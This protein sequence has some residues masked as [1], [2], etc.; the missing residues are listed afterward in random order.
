M[1]S[2]NPL[3]DGDSAAPTDRA[4]VVTPDAAD[5]SSGATT[6]IVYDCRVGTSICEIENRAS[7]KAIAR[8]RVGINGT[9]IR[10]M[11]DGMCVATIVL[12]SPNF[13]AIRAAS[14]ADI[15]AKMLAPKN[16]LPSTPSST[17]KRT[18]NQ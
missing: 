14:R 2:S 1:E 11:L 15:P 10:K 13:A 3:S 12:I 18:R 7:R 4:M 9:S 17:P 5:R 6:A 16:M 8:G